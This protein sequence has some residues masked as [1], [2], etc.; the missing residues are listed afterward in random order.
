M[1]IF[2]CIHLDSKRRISDREDSSPEMKFFFENRMYNKRQIMRKTRK[3]HIV[4]SA[5]GDNPGDLQNA[6]FCICW[7]LASS[8]RPPETQPS[9]SCVNSGKVSDF[10]FRISRPSASITLTHSQAN[11]LLT[12]SQLFQGGQA[13]ERRWA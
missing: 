5:E 1:Y 3:N 11:R 12:I 9:L 8:T 6:S 13:D 7:Q 10:G 2:F 4:L